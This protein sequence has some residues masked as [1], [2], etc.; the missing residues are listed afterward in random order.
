[1]YEVTGG[2]TASINASAPTGNDRVLVLAYGSESQSP[3]SGGPLAA[4][5]FDSQ[6]VPG[7]LNSGTLCGGDSKNECLGRTDGC[8]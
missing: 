4:I 5:N 8:D 2:A 7:A 1:M 3:W 6:T